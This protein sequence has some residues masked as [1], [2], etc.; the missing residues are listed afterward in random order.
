MK[1]LPFLK[2]ITLL[3]AIVAASFAFSNGD[4]SYRVSD[5]DCQFQPHSQIKADCASSFSAHAYNLFFSENTVWIETEI[6]EETNN[7]I[8][9]ENNNKFNIRCLS[10][11]NLVNHYEERGFLIKSLQRPLF[12]LFHSWKAFLMNLA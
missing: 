2:K 11:I 5:N 7:R 9:K 10:F 6:Q 1:F 8:A 3:L 4:N 12:I